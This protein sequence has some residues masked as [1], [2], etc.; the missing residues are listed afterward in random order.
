MDEYTADVFANQDEPI[1]VIAAQAPNLDGSSSDAD[2][3]A[4]KH[5]IKRSLSPSRQ[6][7][8]AA[9]QA[10]KPE[11]SSAG[12]G[13]LSL[14]DVLFSKHGFLLFL[15]RGHVLTISQAL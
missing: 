9:G 8:I 12:G 11:S 10:E 6:E 1:P 7:D 4:R 14:Q 2:A 13:R 5:K 3:A 15:F